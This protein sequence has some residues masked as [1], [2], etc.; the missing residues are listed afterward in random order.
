MARCRI[1]ES[2][3]D[4]TISHIIST[5]K[6]LSTERNKLLADM[7]KICILTKNNIKLE[8][9]KHSEL[10]L[11]QFILD[12]TSLNLSTRVSLKDPIV[13]EVF[14]LSRD[15]CYVL[16]KTRLRLLTDQKK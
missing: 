9:F 14:R 7:E 6:G 10:E 4:E 1:C 16:D 12:P 11:C 15:I 2:G 3:A 13:S 8:D 5:C